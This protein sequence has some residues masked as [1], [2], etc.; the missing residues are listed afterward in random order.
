[1][2][3]LHIESYLDKSSSL[4]VLSPTSSSL[5]FGHILQSHF[6]IHHYLNLLNATKKSNVQEF[7]WIETEDECFVSDKCLSP[8][9][10]YFI[11]KC[12]CKKVCSQHR[13]CSFADI[14]CTEFCA[15]KTICKN[16]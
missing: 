14:K 4:T 11:I 12:G 10:L 7:A 13:Q 2:N 5:I 8:I 9:P 1:M 3:A 16:T 15:C 6:F